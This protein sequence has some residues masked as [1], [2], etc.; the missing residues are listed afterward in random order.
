MPS[1]PEEGYRPWMNI[2]GIVLFC[3][4]VPT[5]LIGLIL[6]FKKSPRA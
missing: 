2:V 3:L 5:T 6:C 4:G 1:T